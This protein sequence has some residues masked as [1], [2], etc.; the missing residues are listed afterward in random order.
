MATIPPHRFFAPD[1]SL[2]RPIVALPRDEGVHLARVLRLR[3]GAIVGVFNGRGGEF[4][5]AVETVSRT[6]VRVRLLEPA[7]ATPEPAVALCLG[8]AVLKGD[9]MD[10]ALRD[11]TML[12]ARVVQ[13]ILSSRSVISRAAV[14]RSERIDRWRRIAIASAKQC[15]RAVVPEVRSVLE[16]DAVLAADR[17]GLKVILVEPAAHEKTG[18]DRV[19]GDRPASA[20][21]LVGPE[22]GWLPDE[23]ARAAAHG[24]IPVTLGRRTLRADAV[25]LVAV[26]L[27]QFLWGDL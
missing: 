7:R 20:T 18:L 17:S 1:L 9:R 26:T 24:F 4:R 12:G 19:R 2:E 3:P 14:E 6:A 8:L 13:P 15:G 22:G 10:E 16:L 23:V 25:P 27:L 11:A 21:V 5:A